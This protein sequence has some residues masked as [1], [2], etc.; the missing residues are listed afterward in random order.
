MLKYIRADLYR[1]TRQIPRYVLLVLFLGAYAF[2]SC[3]YGVSKEMNG[4]G[5]TTT[6]S[7]LLAYMG[8]ALGIVELMAVFADDFRA[9]TM[10][11]AIGTG[12]SRRHVMLAKL[13][14]VSLLVLIDLLLSVLLLVISCTVAGIRFQPYQ[15]YQMFIY[16]LTTTLTAVVA[17]DV[18]MIV[19]FYTQK[20]GLAP[21]LFLL[22]YVDPVSVALSP[23]QANEIVL[24]LHLTEY[25]Y[26]ALIGELSNQLSLGVSF[27]LKALI[28]LCAYLVLFFLL[29]Y[30]IFSKRELD[31]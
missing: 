22:F 2:G 4:L 31:F 24:K 28:V 9:K 16:A 11:V 1:I 25:T 13:L 14:E 12:I 15:F 27:P 23:F 26:S 19:L 7:N 6:C 21:I 10:Q 3:A 5:I 18:T 8:L 29:G 30:T 17:T 20:T